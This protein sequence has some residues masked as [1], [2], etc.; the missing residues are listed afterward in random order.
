M[1]WV[2][3]QIQANLGISM[4]LDPVEATAYAALLKD[5]ATT[6]QVFIQSWVQDYPDPQNWLSL[7]FR[8]DSQS[9]H[10]GW[11]NDEFDRLT[12]AADQEPNQQQRLQLYHQAQE[13]LVREAPAVFLS[14]RDTIQLIK[15]YVK[16][17]REAASPQDAV[18]PG[19]RDIIHIGVETH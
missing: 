4:E 14:W 12:R 11:K 18:L 2:Q 1:E 17:M 8:S 9:T 16:G 3:Q 10:S 13:I 7:V 15:P 6:P 19:I 5:P